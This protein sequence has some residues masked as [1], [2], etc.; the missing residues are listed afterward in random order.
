MTSPG[1][2]TGVHRNSGPDDVQTL[3][4]ASKF[5]PIVMSWDQSRDPLPFL[6]PC[7]P[8]VKLLLYADR[9]MIISARP[10]NMADC[11]VKSNRPL[12][13]AAEWPTV[14]A[15]RFLSSS[16]LSHQTHREPSPCVAAALH[17]PQNRII[18]PLFVQ[19]R[20]TY[21]AITFPALPSSVFLPE[22]TN[23]RRFQSASIPC[24]TAV[25]WIRSGASA[26][27]PGL[28]P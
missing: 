14:P 15:E 10:P 7:R 4:V 21:P 23:K 1:F 26:H 19:R 28:E 24:P 5:T 25:G 18:R 9:S 16:D 17:W 12:G 27:R 8:Q 20:V 13:E 11:K 6:F 2:T 22:C 3:L